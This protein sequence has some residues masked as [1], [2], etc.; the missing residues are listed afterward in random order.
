MTQPFQETRRIEQ[1]SRR[2]LLGSAVCWSAL[3]AVGGIPATVISA[4]ERRREKRGV[5]GVTTVYTRN[6]HADVIFGKILE[7]YDQKGG[8]GPALKLLSLYV[9]QM[10]ADDLS[11]ELGRKHNVPI[12]N[13][14]GEAVRVGFRDESMA[15]VLSVGEHGDFPYTP[16]THQHMYPRRRLFDEI[17]AAF[18]RAGRVVP[19][20]NDKHLAYNW[21][22]AWH[23]YQA[24]RKRKV[25]FMAGSSLPVA[26]RQPA[27]SLPIGCELEEAMVVAY[28]GA[29]SYGFHALEALQCMVERRRGGEAGVEAVQAV[30]GDE[31]WKAQS[32]GRWSRDLFAAALHA[33]NIDH[34][35]HVKDRLAK[36]APF[37]FIQYRDGLRATVAM[38]NGL[39]RQFSFAAKL[40]DHTKPA[41]C[42][43]ALQDEAPY[44]HFAWL[45]NAIEHMIHTGQPAYPVERTLLTTGILDRA[46]HSLAAGNRALET[47][48]LHVTYQPVDWPHAGTEVGATPRKE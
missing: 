7:G 14:I 19:V 6:S 41:A 35:D 16:D 23:M 12:C 36:D 39:A 13:S 28:G 9:D 46:M 45:L 17:I 22:D 4:D 31:I 24:A 5:V 1:L 3:A 21:D 44:G 2:D 29:E 43:F 26:W 10:P 40:Q 38:A 34:A 48:E 27:L 18:D 15:G 37:Y 20:F 32:A 11:R 25:P 42:L 8:P 47:P 30:T 33:Q